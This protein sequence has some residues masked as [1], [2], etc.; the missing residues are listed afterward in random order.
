DVRME[1]VRETGAS[2]VAVACPNC[3]L[4]LEGVVGPQPEVAE[5]AELVLAATEAA[6]LA[7]PPPSAAVSIPGPSVPPARS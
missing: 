3:A 4:M 5:I 1:H 2:M 7:N 6:R